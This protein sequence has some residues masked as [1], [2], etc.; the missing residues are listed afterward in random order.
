M[1]IYNYNAYLFDMDGVLADTNPI[2][3]IAF[4]QFLATKN[5]DCTDAFFEQYI[6]GSNN[7]EVVQKV[8]GSAATPEI[9]NLWASQKEALFRTLYLPYMQ[10]MLGA[11][12]LLQKLKGLNKKLALCTS[13]PVENLNFMLDG[14]SIRQYFNIT[15]CEKDVTKHKPNPDVYLKALDLLN[16]TPTNALVFEDSFR[17]ATAGINAG[18]N[19][20]IINNKALQSEIYLANC[21][22]FISLL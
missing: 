2:H 1:N 10:P 14:L 20:I 15:L 19:V 6:S 3:K 21:E 17:G 11:I 9:I 12:A 7:P 4:K 5:F 13:A 16:E 22:N 8:L 18:C